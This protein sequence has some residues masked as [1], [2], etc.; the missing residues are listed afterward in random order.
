MDK[1]NKMS[2]PHCGHKYG[3]L[4]A[5]FPY[6]HKKGFLSSGRECKG[7]ENILGLAGKNAQAARRI[8][9][10]AFIPNVVFWVLV[11]AGSAINRPPGISF[12]IHLLFT[13]L[14]I[15]LSVCISLYIV[16]FI[17]LKVFK[18]VGYLSLVPD[19]QHVFKNRW[20]N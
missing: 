17:Y 2:C 10:I 18:N 11:G 7:C 6:G 14:L 16:N 8:K 12:L 4:W 15:G 13:A 19:A 3:V 1:P 9:Q 5:L 20:Y